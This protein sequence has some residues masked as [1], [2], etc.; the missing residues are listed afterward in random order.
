MLL[1]F[2]HLKNVSSISLFVYMLCFMQN[3]EF[4]DK[5][6]CMNSCFKQVINIGNIITI[7]LCF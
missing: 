1:T 6:A 4:E 5:I 2:M 3:I 7:T